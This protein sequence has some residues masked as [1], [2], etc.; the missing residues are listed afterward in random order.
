MAPGLVALAGLFAAGALHAQAGTITGRVLTEQGEPVA[1]ARVQARGAGAAGQAATDGAGRYTLAAPAAGTYRVTVQLLGY[2]PAEREIAVP[3]GGTASLNFTLRSAAMALSG[4]VV[5]ATRTSVPVTAVP[6]AVTVLTR[7]QIDAQEKLSPGLGA[8]LTQLVPGLSAGTQSMSSYG[9][10]FRGR[11]VAVLIDGVP[12][13]TSRSAMRDFLTIDPAMVER[14]EVLRGATSLY[15]EGATGG[16]INII[17]RRAADG[18]VRF[19]TDVSTRSSLSAFGDGAGGRIAQ[20]ASGGRGGV[21]FVASGAVSRAGGFFDADGDRIPS[22]PHGQGGVADLRS[23]DL[24]GKVG[25]ELGAQRLELTAN[26]YRAE[27]E[28][29]YAGDPSVNAAEGATKAR[30]IPGLDLQDGHGSQNLLLNLDYSRLDLFGSRVHGQLYYRDY[31]TRFGP[32]DGRAFASLGNS[33]IQSRIDSRKAGA[34]LD[35]QTA[36][37]FRSAASLLWGLDYTDETTSQP[38]SILDPER[39]DGSGGLVFRR[40]GERPWVPPITTRSLG[41]FAQFAWNPW[42]RLT[43]RGGMRHERARVNV[44]DFTTIQG[45]AITGGEL[46]Y[47]PILFNAGAVLDVADGANLYASVSQGFSLADIGRLLRGVPAGFVLGSNGFQA[48]KV[49]QYEV[50]GRVFWG[51][52][53]GSVSGFYNE[54]E[55]G[56]AFNQELEIVRAPER[57]YGAEATLEATP[58]AGV[59]LGGTFTWTEGDSYRESE[60]RYVPLD[61]YRIQPRKLTAFVEHQTLPRWSNRLQ[62]LHSGGRDRLFDVNPEAYGGAAVQAY[63]VVDAISQLQVG[64]GTLS[65]GVENLLNEQYFPV[66]SQL[67]AQYGNFYRAAARGASLSLGYAVRY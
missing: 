19:V 41:L 45:A 37:P 4:V 10:S 34:R 8:I 2:H 65:I 51:P 30:A 5:T 40:I 55:L 33:I 3:A 64:P 38:V 35:V 49:D 7:E 29:E 15:G 21:D 22:D 53:Q 12:Q 24:L 23:W 43:L 62:V 61:G 42:E 54:S 14:V 60:D 9:Q 46:D 36:L 59:K 56:S 52:L 20:T 25:A 6:G 58:T 32:Y 47:T 48:Q 39:F 13:S 27:Q 44:D 18:P 28:T 17:T 1:G 57:V 31:L 67:E 50:G 26:Y 11:N 63:T 66:V 16:V